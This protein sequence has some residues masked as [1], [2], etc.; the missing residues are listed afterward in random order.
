MYRRLGGSQGRSGQMRKISPPPP[1]IRSPDLQPVASRYTDWATR[2][3][4]IKFVFT[5]KVSYSEVYL[6]VII[7]LGYQHWSLSAL[8]RRVNTEAPTAQHQE[9]YP[10]A[11]QH[12]NRITDSLITTCHVCCVV[13]SVI[14]T[15]T[16][17]IKSKYFHVY[18]IYLH[19]SSMEN[20]R[21]RLLLS[22]RTF[23]RIF[24]FPF[25]CLTSWR[26]FP[27]TL[28]TPTICRTAIISFKMCTDESPGFLNL[29][30]PN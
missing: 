8:R 13:R 5:E 10:K 15:K 19:Y 23:L 30:L 2:P 22:S 1:E 29:W 25:K 6:A 7:V 14:P 27:T 20:G 12:A 9:V 26:P 18:V 3:T 17:F 28:R 24:P 11:N 4:L 16:I 21:R